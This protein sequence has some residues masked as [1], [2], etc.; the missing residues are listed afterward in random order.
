MQ[1]LEAFCPR[2][3]GL[4]TSEDTVT[5]ATRLMVAFCELLL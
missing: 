2:L 4:Q 3:V 1:V 5:G